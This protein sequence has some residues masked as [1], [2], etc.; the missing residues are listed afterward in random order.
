MQ[1][2]YAPMAQA[3]QSQGRGGDSM[4]VHMTPGEVGG[5]QALANAAGGSLTTNPETG[6]PEAGFL[7]NILPTIL[8]AGLSFIPG[9]GP[10]MAAGLVGAGQTA[11]TGD[12]GK[13]LMAG[14]G[15][16][17]GASLAGALAPTAAGVPG[18]AT[19][20]TTGATGATTAGAGTSTATGM[21]NISFSKVAK[22][23]RTYLFCSRF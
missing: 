3:V 13:G 19:T 4:L 9:V 20:G 23:T 5:L 16:F 8:G 11:I 21:G 7:S 12:L 18:A 1:N 14:I 2:M 22:K 17:G 6:L 15:A 10:L